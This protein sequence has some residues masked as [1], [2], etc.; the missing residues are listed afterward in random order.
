M[1]TLTRH[2]APLSLSH[3]RCSPSRKPPV[4]LS[5]PLPL[6]LTHKSYDE[7]LPPSIRSLSLSLHN[8]P[9]SGVRGTG[10]RGFAGSS[11]A[12]WRGSV[13]GVRRR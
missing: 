8:L 4:P 11:D 5:S 6:S 1:K 7:R 10:L 2:Q 13:D 3:R 12:R 9:L